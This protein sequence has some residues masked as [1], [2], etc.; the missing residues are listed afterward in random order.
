MYGVLFVPRF[1]MRCTPFVVA[2]YLLL[3]GTSVIRADFSKC[4][5]WYLLTYCLVEV[6]MQL[7]DSP[8]PILGRGDC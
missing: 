7:I 6:D 1:E 5:L 2:I 4:Y 3:K 8:A